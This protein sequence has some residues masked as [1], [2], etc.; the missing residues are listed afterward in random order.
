MGQVVV[1]QPEPEDTERN[2]GGRARR[3]S[4]FYLSP[5]TDRTVMQPEVVVKVYR[6]PEEAGGSDS[7]VQPGLPGHSV[8][9]V[10]VWSLKPGKRQKTKIRLRAR[11]L[12]IK[13]GSEIKINSVS[14]TIPVPRILH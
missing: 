5:V 8:A 13:R 7:H 10:P 9:R 2:H 14:R 4:L 12:E 1:G 3:G 11:E 6:R